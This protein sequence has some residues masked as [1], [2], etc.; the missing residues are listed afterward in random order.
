MKQF[1]ILL[2]VSTLWLSCCHQP[3]PAP[4]RDPRPA[5]TFFVSGVYATFDKSPY[6]RTWDTLTIS[7]DRN[8]VNV[9]RINRHIAFQRNR[10]DDFYDP[11]CDSAVWTG[12]LDPAKD[13][14]HGLDDSPDLFFRPEANRLLMGNHLF[15]KIE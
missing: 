8:Q 13:M 9:F 15:S 10:E 12:T 6:C 7:K 3:S 4:V 5:P 11:E 2:I 1:T 14:M